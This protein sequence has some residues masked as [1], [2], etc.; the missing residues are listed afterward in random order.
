MAQK[1]GPDPLDPPPPSGSATARGESTRSKTNHLGV[2]IK[3]ISFITLINVDPLLDR[4]DLG[5]DLREV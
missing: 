2:L 4:H 1:G 3:L 5:I